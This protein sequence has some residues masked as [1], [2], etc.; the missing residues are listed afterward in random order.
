MSDILVAHQLSPRTDAPSLTWRDLLL[1]PS[2]TL[3]VTPGS[4]LWLVWETYGLKPTD[5]GM[6]HY[7]VAVTVQDVTAK[8]LLVRLLGRVGGAKTPG[9][10]VTLEWDSDR[11]LAADGR[12]LEYV[13]IELPAEAVGD[14]V[15]VVALKDAQGRTTTATRAISVLSPRKPQ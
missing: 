4:N 6:G 15:L 13:S 11:P 12:A 1:Q 8:P 9:Q 7:H 14:Y 2:R 10:G 5:R 3:T